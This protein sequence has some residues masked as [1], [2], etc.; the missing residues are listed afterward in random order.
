MQKSIAFNQLIESVIQCMPIN[1]TT[2]P[3][4]RLVDTLSRVDCCNPA[5]RSWNYHGR[6]LEVEQSHRSE[7][8]QRNDRFDDG[9]TQFNCNG[10]SEE[11]VQN[12]DSVD[13]A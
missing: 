9:E 6:L 4:R 5:K 11:Y 13:L 2:Y 7:M 10:M 3:L 1:A 8:A 12:Y